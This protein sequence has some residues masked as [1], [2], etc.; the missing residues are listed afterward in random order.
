MSLLRVPNQ[1]GLMCHS[2]PLAERYD[3]KLSYGMEAI[4][5]VAAPSTQTSRSVLRCR[6]SPSPLLGRYRFR[7]APALTTP[8]GFVM[9]GARY[10]R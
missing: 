3:R 6:E 2:N 1:T 7:Q 8:K 5:T 4:G 9:L 10:L